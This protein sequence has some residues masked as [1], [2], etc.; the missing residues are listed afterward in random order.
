MALIHTLMR[1][2]DDGVITN[3]EMIGR[4]KARA[5]FVNGNSLVIFMA[6]DY[7]V[8]VTAIKEAVAGEPYPDYIIYNHWNR[9]TP[10]ARVE[11]KKLKIPFVSYGRFRYIVEKMLQ[12]R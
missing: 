9:V 3:F 2:K 1:L 12:H 10:D 8:G 5:Y 11:A 7:I 4:Q 6:D